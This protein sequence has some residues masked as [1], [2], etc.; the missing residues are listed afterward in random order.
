[1]VILYYK[2]QNWIF[3]N[4]RWKSINFI[5]SVND[6]DV[7]ISKSFSPMNSH[8]FYGLVFK[9]LGIQIARFLVIDEI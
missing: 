6:D 8:K 9:G 2:F 5:P 4:L 1:M 7:V 3:L